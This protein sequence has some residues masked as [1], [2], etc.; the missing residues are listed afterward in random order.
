MRYTSS[1]AGQLSATFDLVRSNQISKGSS[2]TNNVGAITLTAGS[3]N[4][5]FN[6]QVRVVADG[7]IRVPIYDH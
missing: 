5:N 3:G 7:G 2:I 4:L 1:T 6:A